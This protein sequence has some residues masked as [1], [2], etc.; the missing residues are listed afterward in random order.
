LTRTDDQL[1]IGDD[2]MQALLESVCMI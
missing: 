2:A 1:M